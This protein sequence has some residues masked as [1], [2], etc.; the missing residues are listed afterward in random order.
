MK[1]N[2]LTTAILKVVKVPIKQSSHYIKNHLKIAANL[3]V[4]TIFK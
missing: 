3:F 4:T 2:T 1:F